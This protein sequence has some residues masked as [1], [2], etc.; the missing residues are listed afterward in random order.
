MTR[1]MLRF[2]CRVAAHTT[3]VPEAEGDYFVSLHIMRSP[4][5]AVFN[6]GVATGGIPRF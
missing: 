1:R 3:A 5:G 6:I 4:V 2:L